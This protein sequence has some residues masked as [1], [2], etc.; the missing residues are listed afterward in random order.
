MVSSREPFLHA[1]LWTQKCRHG[2]PLTE[3]SNAVDDRFL[4]LSPTAHDASTLRLILQRFDFLCICC[5]FAYIIRR[6]Q[7]DQMALG[8]TMYV[9]AN[10]RQAKV[11]V[12]MCFKY[13]S[14]RL[15]SGDFSRHAGRYG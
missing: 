2:T 7:I 5:K 1:Q 8:L 6:Q 15:L 3:I 9:C 14:Q 10:Y 12:A 13:H 11:C 4:F